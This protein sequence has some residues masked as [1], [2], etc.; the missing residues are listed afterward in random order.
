[1][2]VACRVVAK[3]GQTETTGTFLIW[4]DQSISDREET[5]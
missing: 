5:S 4:I 2:T 3:F 1:M